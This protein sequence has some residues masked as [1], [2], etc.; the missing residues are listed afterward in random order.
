MIA[1]KTTKGLT[2]PCPKCGEVDA[3]ITLRLA[4]MN[5]LT[6][7]ECNTEFTLEEVQDFIDRWTPLIAWI[8]QAPEQK[9]ST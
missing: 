3:C 2:L 1:T 5:E 9:E 8:N 6:C 4:D 7:Q